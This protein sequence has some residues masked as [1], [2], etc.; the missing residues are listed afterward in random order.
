MPQKPSNPPLKRHPNLVP[1][2][3]DHHDSLVFALRIKKYITKVDHKIMQQYILHHWESVMKNHFKEEE[4]CFLSV[5][6]PQHELI[7]HFTEDHKA[8]R[9]YI[10]QL[11]TDSPD[12]EKIARAF[13][14]KLNQHI[15]FEERQLFPFLQEHLSDQ[16]LEA[17]GH[18]LSHKTN[19]CDNFPNPFWKK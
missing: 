5:V 8:I 17:I 18:A 12:F 15:R 9:E 14:E 13:S 1:L 3:H 2:S 7:V 4:G 19:G 10:R 16:Q 6:D 11:G